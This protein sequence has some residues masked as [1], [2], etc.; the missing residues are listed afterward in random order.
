[1]SPERHLRALQ[2]EVCTIER[3]QQALPREA[4]ADKEARSA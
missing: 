3:D 4:Y 1:V 2:M